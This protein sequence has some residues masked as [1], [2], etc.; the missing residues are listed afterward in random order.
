MNGLLSYIRE[1]RP[2]IA[3]ENQKETHVNTFS[4]FPDDEL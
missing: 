1:I 2:N 3:A 4:A